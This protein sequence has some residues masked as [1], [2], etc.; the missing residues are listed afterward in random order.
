MLIGGSSGDNLTG[1]GGDDLLI[2]GTTVHET[3]L[4]ALCNIVNEWLRTDQ[5]YS[6]RVSNLLNGGG[7]N[8]TTKL[9]ATTVFDDAIGDN[10]TGGTGTDWFFAKTTAP[11]PDNV[12][13]VAGETITVPG[14]PP[15]PLLVQGG[16]VAEHGSTPVLTSAQLAPIA[17]E[18]RARWLASG[19]TVEQAAT[20]AS[21][22]FTI[23]DLDGATI[24]LTDRTSIVIDRTAAGREWFIDP[25]PHGN[26][27][28][29]F[30]R[31]LAAWMADGQSPAFNHVDLLTVVLHEM[32]HV[33]G[34]DHPNSVT[35]W[36][37]EQSI[38][39]LMQPILATGTRL[40]PL[41]PHEAE[42]PLF[43]ATRET[44]EPGVPPG[45]AHL[46]P[47]F[48][49]IVLDRLEDELGSGPETRPLKALKPHG[50]WLTRFLS[51]VSDRQD[52]DHPNRTIEVVLPGKGK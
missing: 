40:S 23:A 5:T 17:E 18:A 14:A 34:F 51:G 11:G 48:Q 49:P 43:T 3:T 12:S 52:D 44:R 41:R 29:H 31:G 28:F 38:Q 24:G 15:A 10:L 4:T 8:G 46:F 9:N 2:A 26:T 50:S 13:S 6:Q 33:L 35:T 39:P 42:R 21:I 32:G 25:T 19:V 27:E 37:R 7:L 45:L 16:A 47:G 20:L 1:N 22:Q 36:S 30:V